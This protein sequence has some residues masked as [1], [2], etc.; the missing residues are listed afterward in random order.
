MPQDSLLPVFS[1]NTM[2]TLEES[3]GDDKATRLVTGERRALGDQELAS[4]L[5]LLLRTITSKAALTDAVLETRVVRL[6]SSLV[7]AAPLV[8]E[9]AYKLWNAGFRV[10]FGPSW[11]PVPD[12]DLVLGAAGPENGLEDF[13]REMSPWEITSRHP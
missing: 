6:A 13:I 2:S 4:A 7:I 8:Y 5:D 9:T 3:S 12:A 10:T 1:E 11:E